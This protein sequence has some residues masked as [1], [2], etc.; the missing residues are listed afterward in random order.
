[1]RTGSEAIAPS[2][3]ARWEIDLSAGARRRPER[4]RAGSKRMFMLPASCPPA[5]GGDACS[6]RSCERHRKAERDDQLAR[7]RGGVLAGD[8]QRD[9]ALAVVGR[10]REREIEDVDARV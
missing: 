2:S 6:A 10:G 5:A 8:P 4:P 7:A 9:D 1:M 3:A